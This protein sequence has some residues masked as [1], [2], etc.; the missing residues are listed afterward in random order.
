M[1][2]CLGSCWDFYSGFFLRSITMASPMGLFSPSLKDKCVAFCKKCTANVL[3]G[4][5]NSQLVP[6]DILKCEK[7][8]K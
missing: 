8:M 5:A 7:N 2:L 6:N 4:R 3:G 1:M